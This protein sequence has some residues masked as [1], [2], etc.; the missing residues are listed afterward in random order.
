MRYQRLYLDS[1]TLDPREPGN[2]GF[3]LKAYKPATILSD[4]YSIIDTGIAV[5]IP[6]GWV[7]LVVGRSGLRF[8]ARV[9]CDDVGVIDSNYRGEIK[10]LIENNGIYPLKIEAGDR[11]AQLV[12]VPIYEEELEEVQSLS[13]SNR[14]ERGFGSTGLGALTWL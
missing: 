5:E 7:G 1:P 9:H 4:N 12:V 2:A 14:G 11:I 8:K 6:D 13:S 3:D 10:V